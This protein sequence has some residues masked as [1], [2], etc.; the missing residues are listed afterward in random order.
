MTLRL[1][2]I[3]ALLM[4]GGC[5][6]K[7]DLGSPCFLVRGVDGGAGQPKIS[8]R[9]HESDIRPNK[10]FI[11]FGATECED[12]VC[13]R[14]STFPVGANP[15]DEAQGYCSRPCIQ[16]STVGCPSQNEADDKIPSKRL[17]CR[18][19]LLDEATLAAIC[20]ADP[21]KCTQYFGDTKSPFFCARGT[22]DGGS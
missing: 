9:L 3:A 14:D 2:V 19:L 1:A 8:V 7:T 16:T 21:E 22:G 13:V 20:N 17:T 12:L 11:S 10:D 18:P 5:A 15:T 6:V 4:L